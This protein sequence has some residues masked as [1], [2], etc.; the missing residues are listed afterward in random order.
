MRDHTSLLAWQEARAVSLAVVRLTNEHWRP[1]GGAI[2]GQLQ[3]AS[4]SAQVNIAEGY[5]WAHSPAYFRHLK[6]AY[7]SAVECGDLLALL[8]D[9][10][11]APQDLVAPTIERCRRCQRLLLGLLHS[12]R[13]SQV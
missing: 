5:A 12:R 9:S 2:L 8:G 6:I 3:R 13:P 1:Q 10:G 4:V 11:L 7:G